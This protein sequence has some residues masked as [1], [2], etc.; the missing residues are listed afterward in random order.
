V[1]SVPFFLAFFAIVAV[2]AMLRG[3]GPERVTAGAYVLALAGS[4][5]VGFLHVPGDFRVVPMGLMVTDMALL[6]ALCVI[7][8]R[9]NRWWIIPATGCQLVA[10][11]VHAGRMLDPD[12]IPNSY[13][14]LT[15]IWSWPMVALLGAGTWAHRRRL[16]GGIFVPDWKPSSR[17]HR[18]PIPKHA[19]TD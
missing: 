2:F 1:T 9:A 12:M 3:G 4:A 7:A 8:I 13:E 14:F 15:D 19:P 18:L 10:V 6:L 5:Y 16:A 11:L 17:R